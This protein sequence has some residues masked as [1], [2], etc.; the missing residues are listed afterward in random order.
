[1]KIAVFESPTVPSCK[2]IYTEEDAKYTSFVRVTE[3]AIVEFQP[4]A[5]DVTV[6]EKVD[7]IDK[8]IKELRLRHHN[9]LAPMERIKANLLA[10]T[11]DKSA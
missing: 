2:S 11:M 10:V 5:N 6:P 4:R 7:A 8:E 3:W 1:M 9:E